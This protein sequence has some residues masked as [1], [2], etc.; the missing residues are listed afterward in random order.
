MSKTILILF[1]SFFFFV[2]CSSTAKK[3]GSVLETGVVQ[4]D[5]E[6]KNGTFKVAKQVA[7]EKNTG[8]VITKQQLELVSMGKENILEQSIVI[9]NPGSIKGKSAV[10]RPEEGQYSVWFEGKK[11]TSTIKINS[12]N[13]SFELKTSGPT[14]KD[15]S[16]RQ[17][18]FPKSQHIFCFFSQLTEC[19][20]FHGFIKKSIKDQSGS[21]RL[22]LVWNGYP[23]FQEAYNDLPME[24]FSKAQLAYD[25]KI[26]EDEFRF[27]L[28]V[29]NQMIFFIT[30][31]KGEFKKMFWIAQGISMVRKD[32]RDK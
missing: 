23:F 29:A 30:S 16:L 2:S 9:S 26:A 17:I 31:E 3:T 8:R 20:N 27:T 5:Y 14:A 15:S 28:G 10:L 12:K 18:A 6:D 19:L 21:V 7:L 1:L 24:L 32:L 25:G 22:N 11:Y 4:Y 13:K